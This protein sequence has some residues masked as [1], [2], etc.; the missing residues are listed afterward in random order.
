MW[1]LLQSHRLLHQDSRTLET[2][3]CHHSPLRIHA[4]LGATLST[5]QV[6]KRVDSCHSSSN[7]TSAHE[8]GHPHTNPK[9]HTQKQFTSFINISDLSLVSCFVPKSEEL[10]SE[11][12]FSTVSLLFLD[13]L[14][15]AQS[16]S[17]R[18]CK[19]HG[20]AIQT[21]TQP[22]L[23]TWNRPTLFMLFKSCASGRDIFEHSF[24][25]ANVLSGR[26]WDK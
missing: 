8:V 4:P 6:G 20:P 19:A 21:D 12:I 22:G 24:I 17:A 15:P 23:P 2:I 13:C 18:A 9:P 7:S 1:L 16:A 25:V 11:G 26:S 14:S 3:G 10:V 5:T